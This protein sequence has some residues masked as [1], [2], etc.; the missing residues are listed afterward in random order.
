MLCLSSR[1]Y[2]LL[3]SHILR[4]EGMEQTNTVTT[5]YDLTWFQLISVQHVVEKRLIYSIT[6]KIISKLCSELWLRPG[7]Y[8]SEKIR[9]LGLVSA[10]CLYS[11]NKA[12]TNNKK[13]KKTNEEGI[14]LASDLSRYSHHGGQCDEAVA[15]V[16][17]RATSHMV[18]YTSPKKRKAFLSSS[19]CRTQTS[20]VSFTHVR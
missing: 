3:C 19:Q 17:G 12:K 13:S 7:I 2:H 20:S 8:A 10:T 15:S 18:L 14:I 9:S 1:D 6:Y 5:V 4:R 11:V 16:A